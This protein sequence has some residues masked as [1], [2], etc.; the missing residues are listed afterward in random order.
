MTFGLLLLL[1]LSSTDSPRNQ[2]NRLFCLTGFSRAKNSS[3][4]H[5]A[6][7]QNFMWSNQLTLWGF[8]YNLL[9]I[10][11][12][13]DSAGSLGLDSHQ[14]L[15]ASPGQSSSAVNMIII[16]L[17]AQVKQPQLRSPGTRKRISAFA[18]LIWLNKGHT[19]IYAHFSEMPRSIQRVLISKRH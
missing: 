14:Q 7:P 4:S 3:G 19:L 5:P 12:C 6:L 10:S 2:K 9:F 8:K 18:L 11:L 1:L 17:R 13:C 16:K 15:A